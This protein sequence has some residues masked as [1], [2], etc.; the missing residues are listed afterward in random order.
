[1]IRLRDHP[2]R[3]IPSNCPERAFFCFV[4]AIQGNGK[5]IVTTHHPEA[6]RK[7]LS[8]VNDVEKSL[9]SD[10]STGSG[11]MRRELS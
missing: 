7:L 11:R 4:V 1:M 2:R 8:E 3:F 6:F 5:A 10:S 9:G